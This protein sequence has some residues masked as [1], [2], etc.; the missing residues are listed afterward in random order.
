MA[1]W[2]FSFSKR[3]NLLWGY[4]IVLPSF[5][6]RTLLFSMTYPQHF[7]SFWP[8]CDQNI[9][10]VFAQSRL[11]VQ[12]PKDVQFLT[13]S[14]AFL[15]ESFLFTNHSHGKNEVHQVNKG[16]GGPTIVTLA[17]LPADLVKPMS[18]WLPIFLFQFVF[19]AQ[20]WG[21]TQKGS[22]YW[23][24]TTNPRVECTA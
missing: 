19:H 21:Q 2:I 5:L 1:L 20:M 12:I 3:W 17:G 24:S 10:K 14:L 9:I 22:K 6:F 8:D 7:W 13:A 15:A 11:Q 4:K 23:K 16:K 18:N